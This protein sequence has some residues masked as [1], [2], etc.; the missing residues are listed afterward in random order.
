MINSPHRRESDL[1]WHHRTS[2]WVGERN[3]QVWEWMARFGL[4]LFGWGTGW[5]M[6]YAII[7]DKESEVHWTHVMGLIIGG[8]MLCGPAVYERIAGKTLDRI[9]GSETQ[10]TERT[11]VDVTQRILEHRDAASGIDPAP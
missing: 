7:H 5:L 4:F 3:R 10:H 6:A 11:V 9:S 8:A 1:K 2:R